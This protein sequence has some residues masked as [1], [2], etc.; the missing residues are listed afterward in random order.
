[1]V[2]KNCVGSIARLYSVTSGRCSSGNH[3]SGQVVTWTGTA[4]SRRTAL[5]LKVDWAYS[6]GEYKVL[7]SSDGSNFEVAKCWQPAGREE[8]AY[9]ESIM[10]DAP[11]AVKAVAISMRSPLSW[12]YFGINSVSLLATPGPFMLVRLDGDV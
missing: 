1:M 12:G 11:T 10:F 9:A 4:S 8:V 7:I 2:K 6:P 5:G 3:A